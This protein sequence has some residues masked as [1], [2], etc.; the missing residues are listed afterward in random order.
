MTAERII[1]VCRAYSNNN[2]EVLVSK[3]AKSAATMICF[4]ADKI[5]MSKTSELGLIDPQVVVTD[6]EVQKMMPASSD[7]QELRRFIS[8]DN[9][10]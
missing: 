4:G 6:G 1:R 2:F 9:T 10:S 3:M 7:N 5:H 8:K